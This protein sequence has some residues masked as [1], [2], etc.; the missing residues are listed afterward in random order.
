MGVFDFLKINNDTK[1]KKFDFVK[2]ECQ[3]DSALKAY[4]KEMKKKAKDL[5]DEDI[6]IVWEYASDYIGILLTWLISNNY[7]I[8]VSKNFSAD[9]NLVKRERMTGT[10][11]LLKN[12]DGTLSRENISEDII[13][14]I[15]F[16]FDLYVKDFCGIMKV[17]YQKSCY[18]TFDWQEYDAITE[19]V[20]SRYEEYKALHSDEIDDKSKSKSKSKNKNGSK[21]GFI[22]PENNFLEYKDEGI[23]IFENDDQERLIDEYNNEYEADNHSKEIENIEEN[24]IQDNNKE[25]INVNT[26]ENAE[27]TKTDVNDQNEEKVQQE[28]SLYE[29]TMSKKD[30]FEIDEETIEKKIKRNNKGRHS[31]DY[32]KDNPV[33]DVVSALVKEL[34]ENNKFEHNDYVEVPYVEEIDP[35]Y[36][37]NDEKSLKDDSSNKNKH[38]KKAEYSE[39]RKK[40]RNKSKNSKNE[41]ED[42]S[43]DEEDF[44][45][46]ENDNNVNK[47]NNKVVEKENI[48]SEENIDTESNLEN[49]DLNTVSD[50]SIEIDN[51]DTTDNVIEEHV[52]EEDN[53]DNIDKNEILL[54][55]KDE[56]LFN[57]VANIID[58]QDINIESNEDNQVLIDKIYQEI[59][60]VMGDSSFLEISEVGDIIN[61]LRPKDAVTN[62]KNVIVPVPK[63]SSNSSNK[64][65]ENAS[66][67]LVPNSKV[68]NTNESNNDINNESKQVEV[69]EEKAERPLKKVEKKTKFQKKESNSKKK[70]NKR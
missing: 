58:T 3:Y 30:I 20:N 47:D 25:L 1:N 7:F 64:P 4:C 15:D 19:I 55:M 14:F 17:D 26:E 18:T 12:L 63:D 46:K 9:I 43:I 42:D 45:N 32:K 22:N 60:V 31:T 56:S 10:E 61:S 37:E 16:Y 54:S 36:E 50:N 52:I 40:K 28:E 48:V 13:D 2:A 38:K 21:V 59:K 44:D 49:D 8:D 65:N 5:D 11:F 68:S 35:N 39:S 51:N 53:I 33:D 70:K 27:N 57:I 34:T 24:I 29:A 69:K 66:K 67:V 41:L 62:R 23:D 6:D